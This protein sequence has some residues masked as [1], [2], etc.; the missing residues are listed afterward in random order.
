MDSEGMLICA[1]PFG[2]MRMDASVCRIAL[3]QFTGRRCR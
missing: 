3:S 2:L 1:H